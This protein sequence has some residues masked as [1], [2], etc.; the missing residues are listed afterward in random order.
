MANSKDATEVRSFLGL[1]SYYRRFVKGFAKKA[2][3][4]NDL[5]KKETVFVWDDN[6]EEAFQYLKFVLIN[7]PVMAFPD[8]GLDFVLYTDASQTAV[9]AVLAQEQDGKE[10]VIAYASSTLTP[11][12]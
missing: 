2:A 10:R 4:L 3:P 8:F 9:G 5:I 12:Q 11:P 6:C 7:P 1:S